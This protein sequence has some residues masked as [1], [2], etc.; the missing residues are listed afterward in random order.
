VTIG[1]ELDKSGRGV[2][3]GV[4]SRVAISSIRVTRARAVGWER[5]GR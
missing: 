3:K 4:N 1:F 5:G 2:R